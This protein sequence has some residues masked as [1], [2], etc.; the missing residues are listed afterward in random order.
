MADAAAILDDIPTARYHADDFADQPTLNASIANLLCTATPRHAYE[1][2]PRLNPNYER[3]EDDK[4]SIGTVV[5]ALLLQGIECAVVIDAPDY[6]KKATQEERDTARATGHVPLL[7]GQWERVQAMVTAAR[8]QLAA[9]TAEPTPFT[10]GTPEQ[11][12]VW[13]DQGVLCRARIDWLHDDHQ[14]IDDL[15]TN[16]RSAE[17]ARWSERTLFDLHGDIQAVMYR[18]AAKAV[19]GVEPEFRF[20]VIETEPPH[21]LSV[22]S[23]GPDVLALGEKKVD[24]AL[25]LWR[26]CLDR[27]EWPGYPDRVCFAEL[28][29]WEENRWLEKEL[30]EKAA[31]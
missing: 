9:H 8:E 30:R 31:A 12:L 14:A 21:L 4:F 23:P 1:A 28:P 2:H 27:N 29:A 26:R 10:D 5:H 17:P 25:A 3:V 16:G 13:E 20:I 24:Y 7:V 15:K 18:R 22:V 19:F 6:R 11:T